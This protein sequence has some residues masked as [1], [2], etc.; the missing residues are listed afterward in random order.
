MPIIQYRAGFKYQLVDQLIASTQI[1]V[2]YP[3]E[4]AFLKLETDGTL[5]IQPGYAWDGPSGITIDTKSFMRGSLFHDAVYQLLREGKLIIP[6]GRK[7]AD[8]LLRAICI[9]DGMWKMRAWWVYRAV[10]AFGKPSSI[11]GRKLLEAP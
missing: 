10:R 3:V 1:R 9:E 4:T 6:D 5:T 8:K 11:H 7:L 2:L